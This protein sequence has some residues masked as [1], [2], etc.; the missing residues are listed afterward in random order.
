MRI[1]GR[2]EN[3]FRPGIET[4]YKDLLNPAALCTMLPFT[5]VIMFAIICHI[6]SICI[7]LLLTFRRKRKHSASD[8]SGSTSGSGSGS[9]SGSGSG[10]S[11][12]SGSESGNISENKPTSQ[13]D[14]DKKKKIGP[15]LPDKQRF[16]NY[17]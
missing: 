7:I 17:F 6:F 14:G 13:N 2:G 1:G 12:G 16:D 15:K 8:S 4:L 3:N 5:A 11:S 10:S 9:T